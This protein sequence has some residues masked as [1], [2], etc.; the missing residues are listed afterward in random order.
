MDFEPSYEVTGF[1]H[2]CHT[3]LPISFWYDKAAKVT[4]YRG[5]CPFCKKIYE[6]WQTDKFMREESKLRLLEFGAR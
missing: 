1:C 5:K 4:T 2:P 3:S 6:T